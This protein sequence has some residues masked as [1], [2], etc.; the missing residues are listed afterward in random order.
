[1]VMGPERNNLERDV[2]QQTNTVTLTLYQDW[3][4]VNLPI[5][6]RARRSGVLQS[7]ISGSLHGVPETWDFG[8]FFVYT[9]TEMVNNAL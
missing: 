7:F 8:S 1:M 2:K 3:F 5:W 6:N 4:K 9:A